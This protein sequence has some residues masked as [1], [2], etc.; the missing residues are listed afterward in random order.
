MDSRFDRDYEN[1]YD[2]IKKKESCDD[3]IMR[4]RESVRVCPARKNILL[5]IINCLLRPLGDNNTKG[6]YTNNEFP[7]WESFE[8]YDWSEVF[9]H[10]SSEWSEGD[11]QIFMHMG[12][13]RCL[14]CDVV[15]LA[16]ILKITRDA[17]LNPIVEKLSI[18]GVMDHI[19]QIDAKFKTPYIDIA[20]P[21]LKKFD[22]DLREYVETE[23]LVRIVYNLIQPEQVAL[24]PIPD[25][26]AGISTILSHCQMPCPFLT[27]F[28]M[29][30]DQNLDQYR[31]DVIAYKTQAD[32]RQ[33]EENL[34]QMEN[35]SIL[36]DLEECGKQDMEN[37][38]VL[39]TSTV[40]GATPNFDQLDDGVVS[41]ECFV[42][43]WPN[44]NS[45]LD[46]CIR[47]GIECMDV[48]VSQIRITARP[49]Q[50]TIRLP[51][52]NM[53][54]NRG[55]TRELSKNYKVLRII[56]HLAKHGRLNVR[57]STSAAST[58]MSAGSG[59]SGRSGGSGGSGRSGGSGGSGRS[60]GSGGSGRF[61]RFGRSMWPPTQKVNQH[62]CP[63]E[64]MYF[65]PSSMKSVWDLKRFL[66]LEG[67][68][69]VEE[70]IDEMAKTGY[71]DELD[72]PFMS[73]H[74][75]LD[76]WVFGQIIKSIQAERKMKNKRS[77]QSK[78]NREAP[79]LHRNTFL[80]RIK[81]QRKTDNLFLPCVAQDDVFG[82]LF[83]STTH[84]PLALETVK[85]Q[86]LSSS[87][88]RRR[89]R[90]KTKKKRKKRKRIDDMNLFDLTGM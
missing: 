5:N 90:T 29:A 6:G 76:G 44:A 85:E 34:T 53:W 23:N 10:F 55:E 37:F 70:T 41:E 33:V 74:R 78:D 59:G 63:K 87:V 38:V 43:E 69:D 21:Y 1:V 18:E 89:K 30:A 84:N 65:I 39:L 12:V 15:D 79:Q 31:R 73:Y 2:C 9:T 68:H 27:A 51:Y 14:T 25:F 48:D 42:T 82:G 28:D 13:A 83:R 49:N 32:L 26:F 57:A 62:F 8:R 46:K 64:N 52:I 36:R 19:N 11:R 81:K 4:L 22:T 60:G 35:I 47:L 67:A 80:A 24:T 17:A 3:E 86:P 71:V 77:H 66:G 54:A 88:V 56:L 61:G 7:T 72:R 40:S 20:S 45:D 50:D 75:S 16:D 58:S